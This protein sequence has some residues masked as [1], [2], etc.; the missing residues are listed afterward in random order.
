[1]PRRGL[2]VLLLASAPA[3]AQDTPDV[4]PPA[5]EMAPVPLAERF[6]WER[7]PGFGERVADLDVQPI[8]GGAWLAV[9][10]R[11]GVWLSE[12]EGGRWDNVVRPVGGLA[13][14]DLP[15]D[16][17]LLLEAESRRDEALDEGLDDLDP[18]TPANAAD[19]D[20][21]EVPEV[22]DLDDAAI[23]DASALAADLASR[24]GDRPAPLP[25]VWFDP[26]NVDTVF[27]ARADGLWRSDN[28]GRTWEH[29]RVAELGDPAVTDLHRVPDGTLVIGT[30][31]GVR[32]STDDGVSWIDVEDATDGA[33][34]YDVTGEDGYVWAATD[35]AL[36][37]SVNGLGWESVPLPGIEPVR[38]VVADPAWDRGF[39]VATDAALY[40]T[41]DGGATFYVAGRQPL[42][43][44]RTMVHLE[45][46]GHLLASS[47]QGVW[48]SMDGGVAWSTADRQLSDPDVRA[49]VFAE[50]GPVLAT[51][52]GVWRMVAPREVTR[53]ARRQEILPLGETIG[54][55]THREGIDIDPL[56]LSRV[57]IVSGLLPTLEVRFDYGKNAA[58]AA[59]YVSAS[60][61][62]SFDD[63]WS[64]SVRV[65][66]G[67]GC[68]ATVTEY[69]GSDASDYLD[70][71]AD[72]YD[73]YVT[74]GDV[75]SEGEPVAAA[76][77]VAQ[78]IRSYRRYVADHVSDAWLS[79]KRLMGETA[80]V[81]ELPL[82]DQ[83]LHALQI[84]ELDARLDA[85]TD[86]AFTRAQT[87]PRSEESR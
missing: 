52:T 22:P 63:D 13:E 39:W 32:Y 82:R 3:A 2:V 30:T 29:T 8:P 84:E 5:P 37:R 20:A 54:I 53:S 16:E 75:Y 80:A 65:C 70:Q 58:R 1:M 9:D 74:G 57:G 24:E 51:P 76:A 66:W 38:T 48:E 6:V 64:A 36:F 7:R 81:R 25:L 33:R 11:G 79:R 18:A 69:L 34:V 45:E 46:V 78:R 23:E 50:S 12:D 27:A 83:V 59:D 17:A 49:L 62:D 56:S 21:V 4:A 71:Y 77:N 44:L 67:G 42:R 19:P 55:A 73:L 87:N 41:D 72:G 35:K 31:D 47:D 26:T 43:G 86:G 85:L 15:D 60:T 40:R 10:E 28:A 14:D 68:G 61:R